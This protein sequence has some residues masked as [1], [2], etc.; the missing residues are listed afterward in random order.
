LRET[1]PQVG[2]SGPEISP[3]KLRDT[4]FS[5]LSAQRPTFIIQYLKKNERRNKETPDAGAGSS[6]RIGEI[7]IIEFFCRF[8]PIRKEKK[9]QR[10]TIKNP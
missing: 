1:I 2:P 4:V 9:Q 5:S 10:E 8:L 3:E 6:D 7:P